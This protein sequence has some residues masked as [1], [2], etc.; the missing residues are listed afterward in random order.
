MLQGSMGNKNH[1]ADY[2]KALNRCCVAVKLTAFHTKECARHTHEAAN[3][4]AIAAWN[5]RESINK[6]DR[7]YA[8]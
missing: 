6:K 8:E 3:Q 5:V 1:W 2:L 4:S 7:K